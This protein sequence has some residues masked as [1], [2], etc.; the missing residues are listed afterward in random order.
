MEERDLPTAGEEAPIVSEA[1]ATAVAGE[2]AAVPDGKGLAA[3][4]AEES[5]VDVEEVVPVAEAKEGFEFGSGRRS[6]D[7]GVIRG[8]DFESGTSSSL[9]YGRDNVFSLYHAL[10]KFLHNKRHL[11]QPLEESMHESFRRRP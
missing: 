1:E 5:T 10:G 4:N 11:D 7:D 8:A 3:P 2:E 6:F 9:A